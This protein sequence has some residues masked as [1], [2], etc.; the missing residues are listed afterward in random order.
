L[1]LLVTSDLHFGASSSGNRAVRRLAERVCG[2]GADALLIGGDI[3]ESPRALAECLALF[4]RFSGVKLA[5]PGNHDI[6]TRQR[7]E[8]DSWHLHEQELPAAFEQHGFH[9]LHLRPL[10]ID[11]VGFVGSMGWYDYSFRD[12]IGVKLSDYQAKTFPGDSVPLW[13]D[14][15]F[16]RLPMGDVQLTGLL[17]TRLREHLEQLEGCDSVVGL[18]HHVISKRL[19]FHPRFVVP[20]VWRFFNAFLGSEQ[21]GSVLASHP[22]VSLAFCGHIHRARSVRQN[23]ACWTTIGS[24]YAAKELIV[25]DSSSVLRRQRVA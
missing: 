7:H 6:W 10:T 8:T 3:A 21:F 5:V 22:R 15:R 19:L 9:P 11:R 24:D 1:K 17:V 13:N 23:R 25:A 16:A 2:E 4:R 18:L 20:R 12:D 14:A